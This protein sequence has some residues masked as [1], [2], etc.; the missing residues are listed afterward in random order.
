[1]R[2]GERRLCVDNAHVC[3]ITQTQWRHLLLQRDDTGVK[4]NRDVSQATFFEIIF[5]MIEIQRDTRFKYLTPLD[6]SASILVALATFFFLF[7]A[8]TSQKWR[9]V[10]GW[11]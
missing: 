1:M 7:F 10:I 11:R 2:K 3:V 4:V 6:L 9:Q 8:N 5:W